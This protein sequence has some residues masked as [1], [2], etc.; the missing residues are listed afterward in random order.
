MTAPPCPRQLLQCAATTFHLLSLVLSL[1]AI[2][3]TASVLPRSRGTSRH[4]LPSAFTFLGLPI[5][6][7]PNIEMPSSPIE[8][9]LVYQRV[10]DPIHYGDYCG[11]TP[12][13]TPSTGCQH[14]LNL[15]AL[16]DTDEVCRLHDHFYCKCDSIYAR[17]GKTAPSSALIATRS[18]QSGFRKTYLANL[19]R[20]YYL[21]VHEADQEM[22]GHFDTLV[23]E[24]RLPAKYWD[25]VTR[26]KF[27]S[28]L[29]VFRRNMAVDAEILDLQA[30]GGME[31]GRAYWFGEDEKKGEEGM[32]QGSSHESRMI[33]GKSKG[34]KS[35]SQV[36]TA[37]TS[38]NGKP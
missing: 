6:A 32:V 19:D 2:S 7:L 34:L 26:W 24:G 11:P 38:S 30:Q 18:V 16:D 23:S 20:D 27:D 5:P 25:P 12:E 21:C 14:P 36:V 4:H 9:K 15:A 10:I 13:I 28:L 17:Q 3:A 22:L 29:D 35:S 31:R 37:T 8:V 1:T 33:N